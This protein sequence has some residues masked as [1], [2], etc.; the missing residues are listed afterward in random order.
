MLFC[1]SCDLTSMFQYCLIYSRKNQQCEIYCLFLSGR[2]LLSYSSLLL[3]IHMCTEF[4][5]IHMWSSLNLIIAFV[6]N[7]VRSKVT[8]WKTTN[9]VGER[10]WTTCLCCN[11]S[12]HL[13]WFIW[14]FYFKKT[15]S[16]QKLEIVKCVTVKETVPF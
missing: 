10:M 11:T 9:D 3:C 15:K 16:Y 8:A 1:W 14:P 13:L 2:D 12:L 4:Q 5:C 6:G 7:V